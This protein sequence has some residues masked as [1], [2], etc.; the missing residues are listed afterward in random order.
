MSI[1]YYAF[2]YM[3][4]TLISYM[5]FNN[6]FTRKTSKPFLCFTLFSSFLIQYSISFISIPYLN[7]A[8]FIICNFTIC[9]LCYDTKVVSSIFNTF[10]LT[11]MMFITELI[12]MYLTR[13]LFGFEVAEHLSN[14]M[15]LFVQV[16]SSKILLF[17][18]TYL[19]S[20]ITTKEERYLFKF[21]KSLLLLMLPIASIV[22]LVGI[23]RITELYNTHDTVYYTFVTST[24]L[25]MY[26]NIIVFWVHES[27]IK[28]QNENIELKLQK[29]KA[30]L[31]TEYY[32]ILQ[33]QYENSNI[34]VHDIKRHLLSISSLADDDN[35]SRIKEYVNN[36]YD[37]Y[38]IKYIKQ[39]SNNSLINA[40]INRYAMMCKDLSINFFCDIRDIDFSFISDN[41]LTTILD[42]LLE[43]AIE[44]AKASDDKVIDLTIE[45]CNQNFITMCLC[46][47]CSKSPQTKNGE[48][49]TTKPNSELH[50]FGI[51]SIK[52]IAKIYN[53]NVD[54]SFD[55]DN[56][57]FATMV[58]LK[59]I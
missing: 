55:S 12:I 52:R 5:Y 43:N 31:D 14:D 4:E 33:N 46:N 27:T 53:G 8:T 19:I 6:K 32:T 40:I 29:Q 47:S 24:I 22:L 58:I 18:V 39:Y 10:I 23:V 35:S 3:F 25:L 56:K 15:V 45:L 9:I 57:K 50:G 36:L 37:E 2:S 21:S 7:L 17:L 59:S 30:E 41:H 38:Q 48:L 42:N 13:L 44:A 54:F 26:S 51:K 34:L 49:R 11:A 28:A 1:V 20:K 16:A